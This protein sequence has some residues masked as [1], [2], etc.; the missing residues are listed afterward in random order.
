MAFERF[1]KTQ[2]DYASCKSRCNRCK[3]LESFKDMMTELSH[4]LNKK[5]KSH[6][7]SQKLHRL[8]QTKP[9]PEELVHFLSKHQDAIMKI[10][11]SKPE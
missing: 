4:V 1:L 3:C 6:T 8:L 2:I 11:L 5:D 10:L 7:I 9:T